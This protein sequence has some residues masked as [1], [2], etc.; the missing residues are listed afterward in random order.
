MVSVVRQHEED[1]V[2]LMKTDR[3]DHLV[4]YVVYATTATGLS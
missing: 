3:G 2:L 1:T 4:R